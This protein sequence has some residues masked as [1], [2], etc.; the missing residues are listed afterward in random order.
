MT[1]RLE[2]YGTPFPTGD[3]APSGIV[4]V[5]I[6]TSIWAYLAGEVVVKWH[7]SYKIHCL[8][9]HLYYYS[10]PLWQLLETKI[11]HAEDNTKFPSPLHTPYTV[12]AP[13]V[14]AQTDTKTPGHTFFTGNKYAYFFKKIPDYS[15]GRRP[16]KHKFF[17]HIFKPWM[18]CMCYAQFIVALTVESPS[19]KRSHPVL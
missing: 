6:W 8:S 1:L 4:N 10:Q 5:S 7:Y 3:L 14:H 2:D 19:F 15:G 17:V 16:A 11:L 18:A 13:S 9:D 12:G